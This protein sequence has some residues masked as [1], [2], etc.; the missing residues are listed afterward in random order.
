MGFLQRIRD[1]GGLA[2][3]SR[4]LHDAALNQSTRTLASA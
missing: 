3:W 2:W 1:T 4:A